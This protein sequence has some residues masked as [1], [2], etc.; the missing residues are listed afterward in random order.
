MVY[1][2]EQNSRRGKAED[3]LSSLSMGA[4]V[5]MIVML[6]LMKYI[7]KIHPD[8]AKNINTV[9]F[10]LGL[11]M[12]IIPFIKLT[13]RKRNEGLKL[14]TSK[15][16]MTVTLFSDVKIYSW[17]DLSR[18]VIIYD[19]LGMR[20]F[21][22]RIILRHGETATVLDNPPYE[23]NIQNIDSLISEMVE[24]IPHVRQ[25]VIG[26]ENLCPK[27]GKTTILNHKCEKCSGH[28]ESISKF[29][30][31]AYHLR[32]NLCFVALAFIATGNKTM[33]LVGIAVMIMF[34]LIPTLWFYQKNPLPYFEEKPEN[35]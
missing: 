1:Q 6:Y 32:F 17:K 27:C 2:Y 26:N 28:I 11:V 29:T 31:L 9:L 8:I 5:V 16:G 23:M 33:N 7:D 30:K 15:K 4:Y 14:E 22:R 24:R 12:L 19:Q 3:F 35:S 10:F 21:P 20:L 34:L 18:S 25:E 13:G